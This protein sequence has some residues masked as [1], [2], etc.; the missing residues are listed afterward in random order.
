[1]GLH[2]VYFWTD[3]KPLLSG[4]CGQ[5]GL[6]IKMV[7][8]C[9]PVNFPALGSEGALLRRRMTKGVSGLYFRT[10]FRGPLPSQKLAATFSLPHNSL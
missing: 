5:P 3:D 6:L 9:L 8:P 7:M 1:M 4:I 2:V 10:V